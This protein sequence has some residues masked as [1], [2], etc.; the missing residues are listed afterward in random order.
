M[1]FDDVTY[2]GPPIDDPELLDELPAELVAI[3]E[4]TNGLIAGRGAI[5]LRGAVREPVWHSLR[6]AWRGAESFVERYRS[7]G[8]GDVPFAQDALG[9]QYLLR[10]GAVWRLDA[11]A[12]EVEP[13]AASLQE[14]LAGVSANAVEY[15]TLGPLVAFWDEGGALAPGQLLSVFPPLLMRP[16]ERGHSYRAVS[17]IDRL[18]ALAAFAAQ[19]RELPDGTPIRISVSRPVD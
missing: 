2:I 9:D 7:V 6:A 15:L 1:T 5:H 14:F 16:D 19:V 11:E 8:S 13:Y 12:D 18:G 3:L 17:A 10:S 4:Q